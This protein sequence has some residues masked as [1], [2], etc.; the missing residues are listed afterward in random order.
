[1]SKYWS[2]HCDSLVSEGDGD[3][4]RRLVELYDRAMKDYAYAPDGPDKFYF[5]GKKDAFRAAIATVGR[6]SDVPGFQKHPELQGVYERTR[7]A[8]EAEEGEG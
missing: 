8:Q 7:D 5:Q 6:G 2:D 1:M 3:E 4:Y